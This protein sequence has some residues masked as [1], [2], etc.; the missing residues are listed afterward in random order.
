V[1]EIWSCL[2]HGGLRWQVRAGLEAWLRARDWA[3]PA[4]EGPGIRIVHRRGGRVAALLAGAAPGGGDLFVKWYGLRHAAE[5]VKFAVTRSRSAAEWRMNRRLA[6]AGVPVAECLAA[7]ER[8][9]AGLWRGGVLVLRAVTPP[10]TVNAFLREAS[11]PA[12]ARALDAAARLVARLHER[13]FRHHDLH[14]N[15]L[16]L[17]RGGA[18]LVVIDLHEMTGPRPLSERAWVE[19]LARLN[20][21]T[22]VSRN[23]RLRF[24]VRYAKARK[25]DR[26]LAKTRLRA[27]DRETRRL[28]DRHFRKRGERIDLY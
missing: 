23:G 8:R 12:A 21:Y 2:D 15:N 11:G 24:W 26:N 3:P 16:L 19:E 20:G 28:W 10:L 13:G 25:L 1:S 18:R 9:T 7:G 6:E 14:G 22:C 5:A 27:I 17:E 4:D